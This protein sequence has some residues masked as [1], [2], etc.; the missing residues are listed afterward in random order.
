MYCALKNL[1]T[2]IQYYSLYTLIQ[3]RGLKILI[4]TT[5]KLTKIHHQEQRPVHEI[6]KGQPRQNLA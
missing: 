3:N 2:Y 5:D 4:L 1:K 6:V